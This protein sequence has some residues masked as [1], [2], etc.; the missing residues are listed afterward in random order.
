MGFLGALSKLASRA[1]RWAGRAARSA[2]SNGADTALKIGVFASKP[3]TATAKLIKM[4]VTGPD[5]RLPDPLSR[6][7]FQRYWSKQRPDSSPAETEDAWREY[8]LTRQEAVVREGWASYHRQRRANEHKR[9]TLRKHRQWA[10]EMELF[11]EDLIYSDHKILDDIESSIELGTTQAL[12]DGMGIEPLG[13]LVLRSDIELRIRRRKK[14]KTDLRRVRAS[15]AVAGLAGIGGC[16]ALGTLPLPPSG[17]GT[18]TV[19]VASSEGTVPTEPTSSSTSSG[20]GSTAD[21]GDD[22][23]EDGVPSGT[24]SASSTPSAT[25]AEPTATTGAADDPTTLVSSTTTTSE[26]TSS[27]SDGLTTT[28]T[29]ATTSSTAATTSTTQPE[30]TTTTAAQIVPLAWSQGFSFTCTGSG[31]APTSISDRFIIRDS[32]SGVDLSNF[33]GSSA[34]LRI[35]GGGSSGQSTSTVSD[36]S[37]AFTVGLSP[38]PSHGSFTYALTVAGSKM[39]MSVTGAITDSNQ[40]S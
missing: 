28:T 36:S 3:V 4:A 20:S 33:D 40:C 34:T 25:A 32:D 12:A 35:S 11:D 30:S 38:V 22:G 17:D 13:L 7:E 23:T 15:L 26:A 8:E 16:A 10:Q 37:V 31:D 39:S 2:V 21:V 18:E 14:L 27:T 19:A 1:G 24:G 5:G 6:D 9:N 29:Q